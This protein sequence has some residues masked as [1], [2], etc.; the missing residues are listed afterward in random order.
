MLHGRELILSLIPHQDSMCL[1]DEVVEWDPSRIHCRSASHRSA[2][3][4]LRNATG[5][6]AIHLCEYGAQ[7]M[8]V[9]G[10]LLASA[11]GG[12]AQ[13]GLLVS[14]RAVRIARSFVHDLAGSLDV[15]AEKLIDTASSWQYAFRVE[16][17]GAV[18][19]EGRAAVM[20]GPD[21]VP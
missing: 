12:R 11:A 10:G 2:D 3:H 21:N 13:P 5:L 14:L 19:A 16:H 15:H 6:R 18:L 20:V 7:A 8:A 9:H 4:P 1:L 17:E